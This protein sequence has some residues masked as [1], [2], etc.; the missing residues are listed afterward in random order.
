MFLDLMIFTNR[1]YE[2]ERFNS[3]LQEWVH[4]Y[5]EC[6]LVNWAFM[7]II[8]KEHNIDMLLEMKTH[9]SKATIEDTHSD[10]WSSSPIHSDCGKLY[11]VTLIDDYLKFVKIYY[12]T[13]RFDV[14]AV[15]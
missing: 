13:Q 9:H 12:M 10:M 8:F 15:F 7:N 1:P 3:Y 4:W 2:W 5:I 6:N 11:C 14:V